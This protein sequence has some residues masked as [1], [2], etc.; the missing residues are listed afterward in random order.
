MGARLGHVPLEIRLDEGSSKVTLYIFEK[1]DVI[2]LEAAEVL[3]LLREKRIEITPD[4]EARIDAAIVDFKDRP[5]R[6]EVLLS[7][8]TAPEHGKDAYFEWR[9]GMDPTAPRRA[10]PHAADSEERIDFYNLSSMIRVKPGQE[11]ATFHE[12]T[13]GTN[14]RD[15]YGRVIEARPGKPSEVAIDESLTRHADGRIL[16][17]QGGSLELKAGTLRVTRLLEIDGC[18]DFSTGNISFDGSVH[19]GDAVR[20]LFVVTATE[21]VVVEGLIEC[22][23]ISA[24]RN[25]LSRRGMAGRNRGE[26]R[27]DGDAEAGYLNGVRGYVRGDLIVRR[28]IVNCHLA[29]GGSL[30]CPDGAVMGGTLAIMKRAKVGVIGSEGDAPTTISLGAAPLLTAELR[31]LEARLEKLRKALEKHQALASI[32]AA[33]ARNSICSVNSQ[34]VVAVTEKIAQCEC[35]REQIQQHINSERLIELHV[36]KVLHARVCIRAFDMSVVLG[37]A[38]RGPLVVMWDPENGLHY[39]QGSTIK[40][41]PALRC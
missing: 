31:Q 9:E 1:Q 2:S 15:I 29:V 23:T 22:A 14:G 33:H 17:T 7:E 41:L 39:R 4:I 37:S 35:R 6:L 20:D 5:R 26:I 40:P 3:N 13:P 19:V 16:A 36:T 25:L 11:I 18:V 27:V 30:T 10:A 12:A 34:E 32:Y 38:V 21:D 28:E 24:G 8:A